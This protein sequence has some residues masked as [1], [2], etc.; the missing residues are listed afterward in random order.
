[1]RTFILLTTLLGSVALA[2]DPPANSYKPD[3]FAA[4]AYAAA[5]AAGATQT[6]NLDAS[7]PTALA[8]G[9]KIFTTTCVSCHGAAGKGDGPAAMALEPRPANFTDHARWSAQ[10]IGVLH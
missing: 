8:A 3:K 1:M 5:E 2:A 9:K 10:P 4:K 7:D 6:T